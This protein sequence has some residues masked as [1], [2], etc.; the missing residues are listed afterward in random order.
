[1]VTVDIEV[2]IIYENLIRLKKDL[3]FIETQLNI[4]IDT[5][6]AQL[7]ELE[8]REKELDDNIESTL[9]QLENGAERKVKEQKN[10]NNF[11]LNLIKFSNSMSLLVL[12]LVKV[13]LNKKEKK[14]LNKINNKTTKK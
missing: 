6:T 3:E 13:K 11:K 14:N 4:D 5:T 1:M 8:N 7:N 9:K 10:V 12:S 2:K